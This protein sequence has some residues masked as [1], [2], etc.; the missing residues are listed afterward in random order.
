MLI[1]FFYFLLDKLLFCFLLFQKSNELK[2]YRI[3]YEYSK[4][5]LGEDDFGKSYETILQ[6]LITEVGGIDKIDCIYSIK[7]ILFCDTAVK[8]ID[9]FIVWKLYALLEYYDISDRSLSDVQL[10]N[11]KRLELYLVKRYH[12]KYFCFYIAELY[13]QKLNILEAYNFVK[14]K[15]WIFKQ[16]QLIFNKEKGF[17]SI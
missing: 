9:Q 17:V 6:P 13:S 3:N 8:K 4:Y 16:R 2:Q 15:P 12:D 10:F 14:V 7:S 1:K 5:F 11:S